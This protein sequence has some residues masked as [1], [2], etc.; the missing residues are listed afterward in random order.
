MPVRGWPFIPTD[1]SGL[2]KPSQVP[3]PRV[4]AP[5]SRGLAA[6]L[7]A[8]SVSR[9]RPSLSPGKGL[10][11]ATQEAAEA[12]SRLGT[13]DSAVCYPP[14]E[15]DA[16]LIT[17]AR[18]WPSGRRS[19]LASRGQAAER[20]RWDWALRAGRAPLSTSP[21]GHARLGAFL[22]DRAAPLPRKAAELPVCG[23]LGK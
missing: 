12:E 1:D 5:A 9:H 4:R 11:A 14:P 2:L 3:E 10:L 18:P 13:E 21:R 6:L 20:P 16:P 23:I 17:G 19:S 8:S 22:A 15:H 7:T